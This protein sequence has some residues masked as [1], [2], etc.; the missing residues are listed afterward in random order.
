[1]KKSFIVVLFM[2]IILLMGGCVQAASFNITASTRQVNPDGTFTVSVGGDCIGRVNLSVSNGTL[3]TNSVW[4]EQNYQTV[5]VKAGS[6]GSVTVTATPIKG[7]S[8]A[9]ANEY[10]P[11]ARSVKVTINNTT[12]NNNN[13]STTNTNNNNT[14]SNGKPNTKPS[15]N[16]T[17]TKPQTVIEEKSS[18]N[19]LTSL[20]CNIGTLEPNFDANVSE[21]SIKLPKD[22]QTISIHAVTQDSKASIKGAGEIKVEVGENTIVVTVVAENGEEKMYTLKAYVDETPQVYLK[23]K[24]TQI[25]VIRNFKEVTIPEGFQKK[26]HTINEYEISVF[27]NEHLAIIYGI[28]TEGNKNF[29]TIDTQKNECIHKIIPITMDKHFFFLGDWQEEREGFEKASITIQEKEMMGYR[30]KEGFSDYFLLSVMNSK[31]EIVDYLYET[32]EGTLQQYLNCAPINYTQYEALV[33][34]VKNGQIVIAILATVLV[35]TS[36]GCIFLFW[37]QRKGKINE[38]IH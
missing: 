28:D 3:S 32:K 27:D 37:K 20:S 9:D 22:T 13:N 25:G 26:Q 29:Y 4:V 10:N 16:Q 18:N 15:N 7:F 6:S 34:Q 21:Y 38:E 24:D 31:G 35:L 1:M 17:N 30:F 19:L 14:T 11:G 23:Y 12:N 5:K 33:K 2:F 8:D 36:G